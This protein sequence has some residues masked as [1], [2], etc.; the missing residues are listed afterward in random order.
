MPRW[1]GGGTA[2]PISKL[3]HVPRAGIPNQTRMLRREAWAMDL[4][5]VK[6]GSSWLPSSL[7]GYPGRARE[8]PK[9]EVHTE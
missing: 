2:L 5:L 4:S 3:Y 6:R 1:G 8:D 7:T 9:E